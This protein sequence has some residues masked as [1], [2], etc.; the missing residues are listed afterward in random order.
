MGKKKKKEFHPSFLTWNI[1]L[2]ADLSPL[3]IGGP[4]SL[5]VTEVFRQFLATNFPVRAKAIA[6]E[7]AEKKPDL[8]GLQEAARWVLEIQEFGEVIY[9][10]VEILLEELKERGLRYEVAVQNHNFTAQ[11]PDS[12]GNIVRFLD[13]DVILIQKEKRLKVI[14]QQ[15]AN[16]AN[17]FMIGP[18]LITRGWSYVDVKLDEH[19]FRMINT[20]LEPLNEM[21]RNTQASEILNGPA[22]TNLPV[23][24]TGDINAVPGSSTYGLFIGAGFRDVW[25]DFG[26]GSGF[27]AHQDANLLNNAAELSQRIDYIFFKNGWT[28]IVANLVGGEQSD[29]TPTGLWPSDHAGVAARLTLPSQQ[30]QH[31]EVS[32]D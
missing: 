15:S 20:H 8:I 10:F 16:F 22:I 27:T 7:I 26:Q 29:R 31:Q 6:N 23:I 21:M 13:R 30:D 32:N 17:N 28:P 12:N 11:A 5:R 3:I 2:G 19:T 9:D 1:Y 4:T 18:F 24:I 25:V 14:N